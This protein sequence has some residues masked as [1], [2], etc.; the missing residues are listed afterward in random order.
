MDAIANVGPVSVSINVVESFQHYSG[1][2]YFEEAWSP[3]R[4]DHAVLA[5]GYGSDHY[6]VKN[7]WGESG[8]IRMARKRDNCGI[9][10]WPSYPIDCE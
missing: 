7:S 9:A 1:D 6:I 10:S 2:V 5:V 8:Y 3:D 4:S